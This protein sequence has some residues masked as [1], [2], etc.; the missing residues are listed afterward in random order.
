MQFSKQ[1]GVCTNEIFEKEKEMV[2]VD[3]SATS[4]HRSCRFLVGKRETRSF[5]SWD[6]Q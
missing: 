2:A 6:W 4:D 1:E 5:S 3:T